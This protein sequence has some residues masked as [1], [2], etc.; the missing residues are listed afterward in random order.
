MRI[1]QKHGD[2]DHVIFAVVFPVA[3]LAQADEPIKTKIDHL[4]LEGIDKHA[5]NHAFLQLATDH[6]LVIIS[7]V[8]YLRRTPFRKGR[9]TCFAAAAFLFFEADL[10]GL[11]SD[12]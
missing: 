3:A 11:V 12:I 9:V 4:P 2:A 8:L 10:F 7:N 6:Y 5:L 1:V